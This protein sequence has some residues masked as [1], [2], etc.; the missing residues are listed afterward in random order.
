MGRGTLSSQLRVL[1]ER[2]KLPNRGLGISIPAA[3]D[4]GAFRMQFYAISCIFSALGSCWEMGDSYIPLLASR[5]DI[6][7]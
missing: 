2:R 3:D 5:S 4:F 7:L 6:S 1:G